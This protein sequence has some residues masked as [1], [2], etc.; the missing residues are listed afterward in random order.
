MPRM[1]PWSLVAM[2][3]A[4]LAAVVVLLLWAKDQGS[5]S[6]AVTAILAMLSS[7]ATA[8]WLRQGVAEV[9]ARVDRVHEQVN[10]R[11]SQLI[12]RVPPAAGSDAQERGDLP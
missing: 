1:S 12:D 4:A 3:V 2:F 9:G 6:V 10:G 8:V 7:L 11:M 5:A